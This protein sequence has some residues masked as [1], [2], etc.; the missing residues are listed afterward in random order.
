MKCSKETRVIPVLVPT[1]ESPGGPG[2][3]GGPVAH[4]TANLSDL[5]A[6]QRAARGIVRD[7]LA[8]IASGEWVDDVVLVADELV[9]NAVQHTGAAI[10]IALDLYEW[11]AAVQV[12]DG[13]ADTATV[14]DTLSAAGDDDESGRGLLLV[15]VLASAWGIQRD[16]KGK[17]VVA[18]FLHRMGGAA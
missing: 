9:G 13:G 6:P 5:A 14:P 16:A 4:T 15:D 7:T 12:S 3:A 11:G 17:R 1:T 8:G 2:M 18:V 10:E